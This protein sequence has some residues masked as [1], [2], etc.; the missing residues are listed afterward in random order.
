MTMRV[1]LYARL[2]NDDDPAQNSLQ[3]QQEIC[4][5]FAE[6]HGYAIVGQSFDDNISGMSFD[7]RG[8]DELMVAVDADK[9]D[10]VIVKDLSRLGR[11][12]TQTALFID[13]LREHHVRV[14]SATEGVD[15]FRDEDD[16]IIGV[17]GLMNDYYAKDIGKKIRAGYRQKQREGIVIT[18][19]FGY[20]KDKNTGQ[21]KIDAEAAVTVQL[22]YSLYLQ[23][24]GQKEIA[25]R[26]NAAG[27]K[28]PAQ[29][30]AERC[31]REVRHTHKTRDGQFLW[32]YASVKNILMEEAYTGVLINHR[33][34]YRN[35]KA[36]PISTGDWLRH[37]NFYPEI[38]E[39]TTWLLVQERLKQQARPAAGNRAKHRYAGLLSCRDCGDGFIP[40][41]RYW[42]GSQRVEY[43]CRGYHRNGKGHCSSH[44]IHEEVLDQAVWNYAEELRKRYAAELK[45]VT[46][47][48]KQWA[49][50]RPSLDAHC[51][52]LQKE[53]LKL[54]QEIDELVMEKLK[55]SEC[56]TCR[57][58]SI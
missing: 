40:M 27:R 7:R 44:R 22:I 42:N 25:R 31:G 52:A 19:P 21:I 41:I 4:Q 6:Q 34:E 43:V 12:R 14:I 17:R 57:P 18:P 53:I 36:Q 32:T 3:N 35:G 10:A 30:R 49:L 2:S 28:T 9:I 26:L 23:G 51:L 33:R 39:K 50:R 24:C 5:A 55:N 15:T 38:I 56:L 11:H 58:D 48:Q 46:Q 47:L 20:W 37:E 1:W 54:E 29:L 13:Y 16:L 8:L 45:K